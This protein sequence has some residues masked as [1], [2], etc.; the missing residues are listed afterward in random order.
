MDDAMD[1]LT[2]YGVEAT[3]NGDTVHATIPSYRQ[4]YLH[5]VDVIEDY[6]ISRGYDAF[7]PLFPSD[8]T[9]GRVQPLTEAEDLLRDLLIGFGFE[10]AFCNILASDNDQRAAMELPPDTGGNLAP[11]HGG[12]NVRIANIMSQ[13]YAVIRDWITPAL[14]EI[15]S[16]SAG[17]LYPHRIF[18]VGEVAVF[19]PSDNMGS[20]TESRLAAIIAAED[21]SFDSAQSV[22]YALMASL[23][24]AFRIVPW[25]H[26]SFIPGRVAL[27]VRGDDMD[28]GQPIGFLGELSPQVL[29]NWGARTPIAALE[30]TVQGLFDPV[31]FDLLSR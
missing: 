7:S 11:F 19:D 23:G 29:T 20:R 15:E 25:S 24:L 17:A 18:E 6:A 28:T 1:Y 12:P 30:I 27:V 21:A 13:S 3:A 8:F 2:R 4:D 26:P 5:A 14:L 22:V 31:N 10:E 16:H 9:V